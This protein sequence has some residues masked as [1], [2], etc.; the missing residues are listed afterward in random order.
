M[1]ESIGKAMRDE[2]KRKETLVQF[3]AQLGTLTC[4][5]SKLPGCVNQEHSV[6]SKWRRGFDKCIEE[7]NQLLYTV[8][9]VVMGWTQYVNDRL[10]VRV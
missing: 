2:D 7:S 4:I 9:C 5:A 8:V 3:F 1:K 6:A 10:M